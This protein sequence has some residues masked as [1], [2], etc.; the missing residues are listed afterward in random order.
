MRLAEQKW[1][2]DVALA[3]GVYCVTGLLMALGLALALTPG[4]LVHADGAAKFPHC[5][6]YYDGCYYWKIMETGY[7][8]SE[9]T[10]SPIAFFPGQAVAATAVVWLTGMPSI[11]AL[12]VV[13]NLSFVAALALISALI[14]TRWPD[15]PV[16]LRVV[17]L[18]M[19][20]LYPAGLYF[21]F[22]Y[23]ESLFLAVTALLL[24]GMAR[25]W[26][27]VVLALIAGASTGVRAVGVAGAGTVMAYVLFD[28]ARGSL[29]RRV[30]TTALI[31]P[32]TCWGLLAFMAYQH[33]QFGNAL[34]FAEAQKH[35]VHYVLPDG[36]KTAKWVGLATGEPLWNAYNP[37]SARYWGNI[38]RHGVPGLGQAF[39]NPIVFVLAVAAVGHGW[40]RGWLNLPEAA[41]GFGLLLIPYVSRG[42]EMSMASQARFVSVALPSF[43]ILGHVLTRLPHAVTWVVSMLLAAMLTVWT[44]MFV[45][46]AW[47]LF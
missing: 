38:D 37:D 4:I 34:A 32:L 47:A 17:T 9:D 22:A 23:S 30:L 19:I 44:M 42:Y 35:W 8:V 43:L 6:V 1:L 39:W 21:R 15:Q 18:A 31:A 5:F 25:R 27:L 36:D 45:T 24:L 14:R 3:L 28:A 13:S 12:E 11:Y 7:W 10:Q 29:G 16:S 41:L 26:P 2:S 46:T 20:A 33:V 40:W